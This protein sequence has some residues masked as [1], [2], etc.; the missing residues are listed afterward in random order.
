MDA[1][2]KNKI[3]RHEDGRGTKNKNKR[4]FDKER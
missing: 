4:K 3:E 2:A 1:A